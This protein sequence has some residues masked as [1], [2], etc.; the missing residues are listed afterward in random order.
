MKQRV[1]PS[2]ATIAFGPTWLTFSPKG[3]NSTAIQQSANVGF[4]SE[5]DIKLR[6][7]ALQ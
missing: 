5:P 2:H 3:R 1:R 6:F 7:A 4:G